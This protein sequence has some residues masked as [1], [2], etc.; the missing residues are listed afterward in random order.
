MKNIYYL[1]LILVLGQSTNT[2]GQLC[3]WAAKGGSFQKDWTYGM[4]KSTKNSVILT[5]YFTDIGR[6]DGYGFE[7]ANGSRD[8]FIANYSSSGRVIWANSAGGAY[9]D[10][11]Y[12]ISTR[13]DGSSFIGGSFTKAANF[14]QIELIGNGSPSNGFVAHYSPEGAC[15]WAKAV[16]KEHR[17]VVLAVA[18]DE[19][20]NVFVGGFLEDIND[21]K[22]EGNHFAFIQKYNLNGDLL[23]EKIN[24]TSIAE[25]WNLTVNQEG[26]L[27]VSGVANPSFKWGETTL[28][29]VEGVTYIQFVAALS[30]EGL[31]QWLQPVVATNWDH[32]G[33]ITTDS[34]NN[35]Y[36]TGH[37]TGNHIIQKRLLKA[38]DA[39]DAFIAKLNPKGEIL[40]LK[41][42]SGQ[43]SAEGLAL[44]LDKA[45]FVYWTG[46]FA[47]NLLIDRNPLHSEGW[48]DIF[49]VKLNPSGGCE[50]IEQ[51]GAEGHERGQGLVV[52]RDN[53]LYL[54]GAVGQQAYFSGCYIESGDCSDEKLVNC[55]DI[56]V[57]RLI[58]TGNTVFQKKEQSTSILDFSQYGRNLLI[59]YFQAEGE[60]LSIY[61]M[62]LTGRIVKAQ[63]F[64]SP[65]KVAGNVVLD[66]QGLPTGVYLLTIATDGRWSDGI[67]VYLE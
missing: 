59:D 21:N 12:D 16:N 44:A 37:F 20:K 66:L 65:Y 60:E 27:L 25:I 29:T 35:I 19:D 53:N 54:S 9:N 3:E 58:N 23:W 30:Q 61:I 26:Q 2:Y 63:T 32:G 36:L 57:S 17:N 64:N 11:A 45:G 52:G 18:S 42:G 48:D 51:L 56:F 10:V 55:E 47:R 50:W 24:S 67:K 39:R 62:D 31:P 33:D 5:G 22:N 1:I 4:D 41:R 15:L 40:W 38:T 13:T 46:Y 8:I 7:A 49:L 43:G 14:D 34:L 28:E 6:F